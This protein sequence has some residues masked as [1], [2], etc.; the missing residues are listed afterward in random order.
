MVGVGGRSRG[1]KTCRRARVKCG[2]NP[3]PVFIDGLSLTEIQADNTTQ[4]GSG[5][6]ISLVQAPSLDEDNV[7]TTHLITSLF[8]VFQESNKAPSHNIISPWLMSSILPSN[9][10][11]A[12][13]LAVR[14]CAAA[15]FGKIHRR[16]SAVER[17]TVLYT[18][19]LRQLQKKLFDSEQVLRTD[20]LSAT[21][22]LALF[23]MITSKD[24]NGWS[25]HFLGI[26]HLIKFRGPQ[27]HRNGSGKE[28]FITTR[29]SIA[30]FERLYNW[31]V[32]WEQDFSHT[33]FNVRLD[34]LKEL[35]VFEFD[36]YPFPT[37]IFFT[38]HDRVT[39]ICLYN[40]MLL[41][42]HQ[43]CRHI[44]TSMRPT[45]ASYE[46]VS[47]WTHPSILLAPGN[48]SV[49]DIIGEFCKLT[50]VDLML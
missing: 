20:T 48:G 10:N 18:Q 13:Q 21:F 38:E 37:A 49:E 11:Q 25:S 41:V 44:P 23:E 8:T 32:K 33:Y 31:R 22:L 28:L 6:E 1:C 4:A 46:N 40:A 47:S 5:K 2:F 9:H 36:F 7:F 3:F 15:Y 26:G 35:N 50:I 27:L 30:L 12:P 29:P 34:I 17:G 45:L 24:M 19:A 39:E 16:C 14:A 42:L 43:M